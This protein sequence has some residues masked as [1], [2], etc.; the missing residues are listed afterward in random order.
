MWPSQQSIWMYMKLDNMHHHAI[1]MPQELWLWY[2][3]T[4]SMTG[5]SS[6]TLFS[7]AGCSLSGS[8]WGEEVQY[9]P[10]QKYWSAVSLYL[11]DTASYACQLTGKCVYTYTGIWYLDAASCTSIC[12]PS[13]VRCCIISTWTWI[14]PPFIMQSKT[15]VIVSKKLW[16]HRKDSCHLPWLKDSSTPK[17]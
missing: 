3:S 5:L 1:V 11:N 15:F 6:K 8:L 9:G 10:D 7:C 4:V 14:L 2:V 16:T 13:R 17:L 12:V